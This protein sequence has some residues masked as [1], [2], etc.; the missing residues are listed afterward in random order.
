MYLYHAPLAA[1]NLPP[2]GM[3][4]AHV[5]L[6]TGVRLHYAEAGDPNAIPLVMLHGYSDSWFSFSPV[7]PLLATRF[8]VYAIDQRGHGNSECPARDYTI[9][10]LAAD[11][12]A[13]LDAMN[14]STAAVVGHSMGTLVAQL[15]ALAAP[16]RITRL[17]LEGAGPNLHFDVA[18][19]LAA[20]VATFDGTVPAEFVREFQ[21]GSTYRPQPDDFLD[22][23]VAESL[24]MPAWVWQ[25]VLDG[26][27]AVDTT[28]ELE[29]I[30]MPVLLL[31]GDKD[32]VFPR[33]AQDTPLAGLA[34]A[35]LRVYPDT[36]HTPHWEIPVQY[37]LDLVEFL[38]EGA[39]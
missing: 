8:H 30:R 10:H 17:V 31:W 2:D 25:A 18:Q 36:G 38:E 21:A 34:S 16:E 35:V 12:V 37:V 1:A 29:R 23:I 27:L 5:D 11:I 28:T 22:R 13:F 15:V 3:R 4:F 24:K 7:L 14:L 32:A 39:A 9:P 26:L 20:V 6:A 19:E 33:A